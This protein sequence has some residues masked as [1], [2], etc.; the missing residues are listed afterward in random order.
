MNS[1]WET[2]SL[3]VLSNEIDLITLLLQ[4]VDSNKISYN[5]KSI[6]GPGPIGVHYI[7]KS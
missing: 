2:D 7:R 3:V 4:F 6:K 5:Y 1:N